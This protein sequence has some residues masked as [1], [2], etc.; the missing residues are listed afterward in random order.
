MK[1]IT[2]FC[3]I[4][5]ALSFTSGSK[6]FSKLKTFVFVPSGTIEIDEKKVSC[7]SFYMATTEVTNF[8][9]REF[10]TDLKSA[11]ETENYKTALP[12]TSKWVESFKYNYFEPMANMYFSHPAY[13]KYPVVNVSKDGADLY[14]Q[15]LTHK[16]R[17]LFPDQNFNDFR[18]PTREEWIYAAKGGLENSPY[19][20]G[21]PSTMNANGNYLANYAQI[22]DQ[23]II[24]TEDGETK[25]VPEKERLY[26]SADYYQIVA[27]AKSYASNGYGLYNMSGNC[28]ELVANEDVVMG[29]S[30]TSPG[31]DIKV[32]SSSKYKGANPTVGFR[33]VVSYIKVD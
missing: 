8:Q 10:L 17:K 31:G 25:I 3:A 13:D 30:W 16:M 15:W 14:C 12:D 24:K 9:Y 6:K 7:N 2:L 20:W 33:P 26:A 11:G 21:G 19:P 5:M 1:K 29:G 4:A 18:L 23:N 22:G 28:A 27:P 32:T